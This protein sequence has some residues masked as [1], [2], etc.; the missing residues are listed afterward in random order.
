M[1]AN[2]PTFTKSHPQQLHGGVREAE[3]AINPSRVPLALPS[4]VS[5]DRGEAA[6]ARTQ[7]FPNELE[8]HGCPRPIWNLSKGS[9]GTGI[10]HSAWSFAQGMSK[11]QTP[12]RQQQ[13]FKAA[14]KKRL[15]RQVPDRL[16]SHAN[17]PQ[18]ATQNLSLDS[19]PNIKF[20][21]QEHCLAHSRL[22]APKPPR[23]PRS[24]YKNLPL[25]E[26]QRDF[27][28]VLSPR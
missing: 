14:Q 16:L 3:E 24:A 5:Y 22:P 4:S 19:T 12:A 6:E 26:A 13:R 23:T 2:P 18:R 28:S 10:I 7:W 8:P 9:Q 21:L 17:L 1:A 11:E 25:T 15:C 27:V 20:L